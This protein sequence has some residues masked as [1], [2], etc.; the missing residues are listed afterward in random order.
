MKKESTLAK[1]IST[2]GERAAYD[3][4]CKKLLSNKEILA[5]ILKSCLSEYRDYSVAEIAGKYIEGE[6]QISQIPVHRDETVDIS[7]IRGAATEDT[8]ISEGTVTYDVRFRAIVPQSGE[9]IKLII[10]VEAQNDFYPG[11]PIVT[12]S[13]YY[14]CRMI[15]AQYQTEFAQSDYSKIKK[16]YSIFICMNPPTYRKNTINRYRIQ[17]E[18]LVGE[19][20]EEESNYDLMTAVIIC[21]GDKDSTTVGI[22]RLLEV[23]FSPKRA[24]AEKKHILEKEF[25]VKMI[26]EMENEVNEMCNLSKG[27][28]E[29]GIQKGIQRGQQEG[30]LNSLKNL[31]ETMNLAME[32]A[33]D[34][35]KIPEKDRAI[36]AEYLKKN[37]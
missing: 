34:A 5:W 28:E 1:M 12:R 14:C 20:S 13:V 19:A 30:I 27:I 24:A 32:N 29:I 31:M 17:E 18:R 33:M 35:L 4:A 2:A 37:K 23:L 11:Y 7:E 36:Y 9:I 26:E 25:S 21:I 16:V 22:L 6:T 15:S 8:S 3:N 10:N